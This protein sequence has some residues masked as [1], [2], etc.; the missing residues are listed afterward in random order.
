[1][2]S[3]LTL[4]FSI[5]FKMCVGVLF[6]SMSKTVRLESSKASLMAVRMTMTINGTK[7]KAGL[8]VPKMEMKP[9]IFMIK[10]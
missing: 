8:G 6:T 10:K 3:T 2:F 7:F 5:P 4:K 9:R 1:M